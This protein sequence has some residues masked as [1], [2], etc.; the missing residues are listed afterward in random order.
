MLLL[1]DDKSL[2]VKVSDA[3][4]CAEGKYRSDGTCLNRYLVDPNTQC[5]RGVWLEL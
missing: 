5:F 3:G 1:S 4:R 2:A